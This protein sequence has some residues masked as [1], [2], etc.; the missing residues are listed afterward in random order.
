MIRTKVKVKKTIH[1]QHDRPS[2]CGS[3]AY[4]RPYHGHYYQFSLTRIFF[5]SSIL[6]NK[7]SFP[8]V[9]NCSVGLWRL[10]N[11]F[12]CHQPSHFGIGVVLEHIDLKMVSS[13][14]KIAYSEVALPRTHHRG[15]PTWSE[16]QATFYHIRDYFCIG[17][18][19]TPLWGIILLAYELIRNSVIWIKVFDCHSP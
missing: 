2:Q 9:R 17:K 19:A 4:R 12:N 14:N 1:N 15:M 5:F 3:Y 11:G 16:R 7:M 10:P 18:K 13:A 6:G 8:I